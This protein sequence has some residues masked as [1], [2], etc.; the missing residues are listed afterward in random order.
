MIHSTILLMTFMVGSGA[1]EDRLVL[2][3]NPKR[4]GVITQKVVVERSDSVFPLN[5]HAQHAEKYFAKKQQFGDS[6]KN[7]EHLG[8]MWP[9]E[10]QEPMDPTEEQEETRDTVGPLLN[11]QSIKQH[12]EKYYKVKNNHFDNIESFKPLGPMAS[13]YRQSV[14]KNRWLEAQETKEYW[15]FT[16]GIKFRKLQRTKIQLDSSKDSVGMFSFQVIKHRH[17]AETFG[18]TLY[19]DKPLYVFQ[20]RGFQAQDIV[21]TKEQMEELVV[22]GYRSVEKAD[23]QK[24]VLARLQLVQHMD[25]FFL[26]LEGVPG[27]LRYDEYEKVFEVVTPP[28]EASFIYLRCTMSKKRFLRS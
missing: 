18:K 23:I 4:S 22:A 8:P 19:R 11:S 17:S 20:Q 9:T 24:P 5:S 6:L 3:T 21:A 26:H 1:V 15:M 2:N 14:K 27:A 25:G 16:I 28:Y 10:E 7:L 13:P 12:A